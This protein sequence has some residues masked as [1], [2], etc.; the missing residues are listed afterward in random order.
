MEDMDNEQN[1]LRDLTIEIDFLYHD[2]KQQKLLKKIFEKIKEMNIQFGSL[3]AKDFNLQNCIKEIRIWNLK[4]AKL[5]EILNF[6]KTLDEIFYISNGS[7]DDE[8][9]IRLLENDFK[10]TKKDIETLFNYSDDIGCR[11]VFYD[12]YDTVNRVISILEDEKVSYEIYSLH[13]GSDIESKNAIILKNYNAI[14]NIIDI[15]EK[16]KD[17]EFKIKYSILNSE[18]DIRISDID[19]EDYDYDEEYEDGDE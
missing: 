9:S 1:C 8:L 17:I 4:S 19:D 2:G 16:D 15:L 11:V 14:M 3:V 7:N 5:K 12:E 13:Y 18:V 6:I 10:I